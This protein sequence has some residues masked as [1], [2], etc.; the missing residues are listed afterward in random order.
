MGENPS[1]T[2]MTLTVTQ[3]PTIARG[4]CYILYYMD[5]RLC[6]TSYLVLAMFKWFRVS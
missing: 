4:G 1:P 2:Y 6:L 3:Q 5:E